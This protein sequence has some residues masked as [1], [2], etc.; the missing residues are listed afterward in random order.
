MKTDH[1][2]A[3]IKDGGAAF[4]KPAETIMNNDGRSGT[5]LM[6][7][8]GMSL[9]DYFAGQS[10]AGQ[11]AS[12]TNQDNIASPEQLADWAYGVADAMIA[13]REKA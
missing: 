7:N 13:R 2:G 5:W 11:M 10:L 3:I 6:R 1:N 12:F 4:P 9:R 8:D